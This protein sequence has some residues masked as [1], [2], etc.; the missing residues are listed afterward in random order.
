MP[1]KE[2]IAL[3]AKAIEDRRKE[4]IAQPLSR[5]YPQLAEAAARAIRAA[6]QGPTEG[7][8]H[9]RS[10][11]RNTGTRSGNIIPTR[12]IRSGRWIG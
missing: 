10:P 3:T 11:R 2:L 9:L 8:R 7:I 1:N 6:L 4:L 5:I 12:I